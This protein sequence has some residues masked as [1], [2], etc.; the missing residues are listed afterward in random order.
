MKKLFIAGLV[1]FSF[2]SSFAQSRKDKIAIRKV[3]STQVNAWN[4]GSIDDFMKGYWQNDSLMFIGKSGITYGWHTTLNNYKKHY[5]DTASMGRLNFDVLEMK[6]LSSL[7]YY[8]IGKWDLQ[9]S[10][11]SLGGYFTLLFKKIK[12][13]WFIIA[14]HTD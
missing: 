5:P 12:T 10:S 1:I 13:N 2:L 6:P 4:S 7:Y 14:D 9:R 8:V 3:L 11:G